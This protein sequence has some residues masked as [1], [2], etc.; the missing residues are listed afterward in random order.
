MSGHDAPEQAVEV[1]PAEQYLGHKEGWLVALSVVA[2]ATLVLS[3]AGFMRAGHV[4]SAALGSGEYGGNCASCHGAGGE[5]VGSFP[6]F[7]NGAVVATFPNP[8]DHVRWVIL[9]SNKGA[10]LYVAAGKEVAGGMPTWAENGMSLT[11][12][13]HAVIYVRQTLSGQP[14]EGDELDQ[15]DGLSAVIADY[16][17]YGYTQAEVDALLAEIEAL[18][19]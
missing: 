10:D 15:W 6:G 18:A 4:E 14:L 8:V 5:G 19:G 1:S 16:P 2:L 17:E 12:I 7:T 11:Q 13:V 9:G 3:F